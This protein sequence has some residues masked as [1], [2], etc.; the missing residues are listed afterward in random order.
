MQR[1][2]KGRLDRQGAIAAEHGMSQS[3]RRNA[4]ELLR[5]QDGGGVRHAAQ[6]GMLQVGGLFLDG[7][8]QARM[9]MAEVG[10]PP[11]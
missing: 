2:L 3:R 1:N 10:A 11:G 4:G 8:D 6:Q 5:Q 9:A 7:F